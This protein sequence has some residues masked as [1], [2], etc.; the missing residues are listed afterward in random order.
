MINT[1]PLD[2]SGIRFR[3]PHP[4]KHFPEH[5]V[6]QKNQ[7]GF[8]ACFSCNITTVN[9]PRIN[10]ISDEPQNFHE[11]WCIQTI[12]I[13]QRGLMKLGKIGKL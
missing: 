10:T 2:I 8:D 4:L 5:K 9:L 6:Y 1:D 13:P 12:S 11:N 7:V 3:G